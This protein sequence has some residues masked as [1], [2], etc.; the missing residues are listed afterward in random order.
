MLRI[1]IVEHQEKICEQMLSFLRQFGKAQKQEISV[2]TF[3]RTEAF[4]ADY[5]PVYD[6]V[7]LDAELPGLGGMEAARQLRR[8]D[9]QVVLVFVASLARHV[10]Q[11]Y[12]V[13][14]LDVLMKPLNDYA[15]SVKLERAIQ[16]V[17]K[18]TRDHVM[19]QTANRI[20][21]VEIRSIYYV[22]TKNRMLHYHTAD[23]DFVVR[24]C[25][26]NVEEQ[27]SPYSFARCNQ[28]YLVNLQHVSDVQDDV[29][30]VAGVPLGMSR[31][32]KKKFLAAVIAYI[33]GT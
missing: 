33:G 16:R 19:L 12:E 14:A 9:T 25:L 1:A 13:D 4:L 24:G 8:L 6:I 3:Q 23:G 32:T 10:M 5:R 11:G 7:L 30:L 17:R 27:L 28:C 26:Q 20:H 29:V 15:F 31:R 21:R 18:R 2:D 22:E